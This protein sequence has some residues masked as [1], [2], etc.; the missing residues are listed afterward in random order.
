MSAPA[1]TTQQTK[2]FK[3]KSFRVAVEGA[4]T[5]GRNIE[6]AWIEQ[7]A[8]N[9]KPATYGA[10]INM[11][12]LRSYYPDSA[13]RSYGD[14]LSVEARQITDGDLK[15]K[16]ALYATID[17]LP[18]LVDMTT[19]LKQK[20]YTSIEVNPKFA[21]T[22][23]AYLMGIAVTDTPASLGTEMLSFCAGQP[24]DKNPLAARKTSPD[25][26]FTAAEAVEMVFEEETEDT[27]GKFGDTLKAI[28]A[29]FTGS[30]KRTD[31]GFASFTEALEQIT[32][33]ITANFETQARER[34]WDHRAITKLTADLATIQ[35]DLA[36]LRKLLDTTDNSQHS[37]RPPATGGKGEVEAEF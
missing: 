2:K 30:N 37:Q 13:F 35:T 20:V 29:R 3:A 16:L 32:G 7:M 8:K 10:R 19:K 15:G 31:E 36:E 6:R 18:D 25:C 12:H 11:E 21:D 17:P 34:D 4:T 23:Q 14:V 22:G 27:A 28:V 1:K 5:D 24:A 9:Y 26:L 33:H